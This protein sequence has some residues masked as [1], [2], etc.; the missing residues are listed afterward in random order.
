MQCHVTVWQSAAVVAA[1][2]EQQGEGNGRS[3]SRPLG[4]TSGQPP[5][6]RL[7]PPPATHPPLGGSLCLGPSPTVT[8]SS[9]YGCMTAAGSSLLVASLYF[10]GIGIAVRAQPLP[11]M[12]R[13]LTCVIGLVLQTLVRVG[14]P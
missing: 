3:V 9:P 2:T 6:L 8:A 7:P 13:T 1:Q 10:L 12:T 5:L 14:T 11:L 4:I